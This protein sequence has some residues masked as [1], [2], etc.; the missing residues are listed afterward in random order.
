MMF[1]RMGLW[2]MALSL[3]STVLFFPL[4]KEYVSGIGFVFGM[5]L[6]WV[7]GMF[8]IAKWIFRKIYSS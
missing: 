7:A 1:V 5:V 3:F 2:I 4:G 8:V 6:S